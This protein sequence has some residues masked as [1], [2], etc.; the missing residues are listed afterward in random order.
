MFN[1]IRGGLVLVVVMAA[2][3]AV[4]EAQLFGKRKHDCCC[5]T[6]NKPVAQCGCAAIVPQTTYQP[7]L[8]TQYA[9]QPVLTQRDVVETQYR[10]EPV[11]QT[12]PTTAY[13]T[14]AVDEGGYQ[15]VWVPK[16]VAKQAQALLKTT[17]DP[18]ELYQ[19]RIV[20]WDEIAGE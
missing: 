8:E 19:K 20:T 3:P 7:V 18:G 13:D 4:S 12:V 16:I 6:C 10:T 14:V 2:F 1:L 11:T 15:Q 17:E 5:H 9:Q